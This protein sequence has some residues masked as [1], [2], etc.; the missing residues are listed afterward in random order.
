MT[1]K[2][3]H[4]TEEQLVAHYYHDDDARERFAAEQHVADCAECAQRLAGLRAFLGA[5]EAPEVPERGETYG[6]DVW[7]RLRAHLPAKPARESKGWFGI[8]PQRWA[9]GGAF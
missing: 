5:V 2:K 9:L 8:A 6:A 3:R 7:G 1:T 4:L